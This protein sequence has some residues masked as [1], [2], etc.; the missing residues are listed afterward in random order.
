MSKYYLRT[1]ISFK[2]AIFHT[3]SGQNRVF[4]TKNQSYLKKSI[5]EKNY[6]ISFMFRMAQKFYKNL[7]LLL[8]YVDRMR[9][10]TN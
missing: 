8:S 10:K 5:L 1:L 4:D 6:K 3:V 2:I 9:K 7:L